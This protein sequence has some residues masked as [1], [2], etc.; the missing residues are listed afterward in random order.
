MDVVRGVQLDCKIKV[1]ICIFSKRLIFTSSN[2]SDNVKNCKYVYF[3]VYFDKD[4]IMF[5]ENNEVLHFFKVFVLL[6]IYLISFTKSILYFRNF[7]QNV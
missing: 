2:F 3:K 1:F 6:H 7:G 5:D 4:K